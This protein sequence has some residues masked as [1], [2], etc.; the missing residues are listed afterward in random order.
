[1]IQAVLHLHFCA[2]LDW[3]QPRDLIE[4]EEDLRDAVVAETGQ[5]K[6]DDCSLHDVEEM[7][8]WLLGE[9][10]LND[11]M[12]EHVEWLPDELPELEQAFLRR[13]YDHG[14]DLREPE[15]VAAE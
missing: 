12:T 2:L 7:A 1:M 13:I 3:E 4:A 5:V 11:Q 6:F 10:E 14:N 15:P 9:V 8:L